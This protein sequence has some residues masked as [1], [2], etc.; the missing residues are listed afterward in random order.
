MTQHAMHRHLSTSVAAMVALMAAHRATSGRDGAPTTF[1]QDQVARIGVSLSD[2]EPAA[3]AYATR[4]RT[5][6]RTRRAGALI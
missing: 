6:K 3:P 2:D 5:P 1:S 4:S